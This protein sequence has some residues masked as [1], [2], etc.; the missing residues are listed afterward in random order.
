[1]FLFE[2]RWLLESV[3]LGLGILSWE[4]SSF[5]VDFW[6]CWAETAQAVR[7]THQRADL[8]GSIWIGLRR[9]LFVSIQTCTILWLRYK[10][11]VLILF[12]CGKILK[13]YS[14]FSSMWNSIFFIKTHVETDVSDLVYFKGTKKIWRTI[15]SC[16]RK[17][18]TS[19]IT[20]E[21]IR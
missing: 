11:L 6:F 14:I 19:S 12:Q 3:T 5:C 15:C 2:W 9:Y 13:C 18:R 20:F 7:K 17:Y 16:A 10:Y 8:F 21:G 4:E 1:M